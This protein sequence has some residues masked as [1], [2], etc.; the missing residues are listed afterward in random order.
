[1]TQKIMALQYECLA[2]VTTKQSKLVS[3]IA[4][5]EQCFEQ[6]DVSS[7]LGDIL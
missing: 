5:F 2:T 7:V 1:M 4:D 6:G 3:K